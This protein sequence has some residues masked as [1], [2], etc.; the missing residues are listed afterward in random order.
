MTYDKFRITA[1]KNIILN[2]DLD[3]TPE[4]E[5]AQEAKITAFLKEM[6]KQEESK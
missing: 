3:L 2:D 5:E 4:E 1:L 6:R